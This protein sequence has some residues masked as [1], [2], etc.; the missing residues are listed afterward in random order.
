[1]C[2]CLPKWGR[3]S[4]CAD[5]IVTKQADQRSSIANKGLKLNGIQS[6]ILSKIIQ[7]L[8]LSFHL[9]YNYSLLISFKN[10]YFLQ[11]CLYFIRNIFF[12]GLLCLLVKR[13]KIILSNRSCK[14]C[15]IFIFDSLLL[16]VIC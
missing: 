10:S 7:N 5:A 9:S 14:V 12:G 2:A 6:L 4:V 15:F 1:M 11:I 8:F 3:E 13:A 16:Y